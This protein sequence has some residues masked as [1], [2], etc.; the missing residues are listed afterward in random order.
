MDYPYHARLTLDRLLPCLEQHFAQAA[1]ANDSRRVH[2]PAMNWARAAGCHSD[3][4]KH[5]SA[6]NRRPKPEFGAL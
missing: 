4:S 1:K 2:R 6:V 5:G 3:Q